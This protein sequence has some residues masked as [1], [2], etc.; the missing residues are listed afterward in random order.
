M[1]QTQRSPKSP[2]IRPGS[3]QVYNQSSSS[4]S[5][6]KSSSGS[7]YTLHKNNQQPK[8]KKDVSFFGFIA[9]VLTCRGDIAAADDDDDDHFAPP[10]AIQSSTPTSLGS[11]QM[12]SHSASSASSKADDGL[13][14]IDELSFQDICK[15]TGNFSAAN[16]IG[17]GGFGTVYKGKLK[18][19]SVIAIKRAK[20]MIYDKGIPKEFKNEILTLSKI[21]HLNLVKFYG[22]VEHGDERIILVEYVSNGTLREHLDGK[23]GNGL[24][25]GER[26]DI[27]I[28]VA[29]AIT[30]L[31]TYTDQPI[32]HR[33]IKSANV[34]ITDKLR[35]KV[36]DFGFARIKVEDP[37]ATH[38][39]TQV[40]GTA[41]YM[42][43][44]YISTY[45]LTDRS[46]V[47]SF[48]VLLMELVTGRLPI[49]LSKPN[50]E[51]YTIKWALQK[52]K[53]GEV[54]LAMDPKLRRNPPSLMV[55]EKV[56]RLAR[57]CVAPTKQS[58]PSMRKCAEILWRVRKDYHEYNDVMVG[59][60]H[61]VQIPEID[62]RKN[63]REFFG[64]E[65]SNDQRFLQSA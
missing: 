59:A 10:A 60:N 39:S 64:I 13:R 6:S 40:R 14:G 21:E 47:Y 17:E 3:G 56:L 50:S 5:N 16:I 22:F 8:P 34:L 54:V 2:M 65:D 9:R 38:I 32:I 7:I 58:R 43:P 30:Y 51:K 29:H 15:A 36:A 45:Q 12:L 48:G 63:R 62:A 31:H 44:E 35:A 41:G 27:M 28:D 52:L 18:N 49:E 26:L 20:K 33:D 25:I 1:N 23:R 46:D 42:D 61:S 11:N 57:Q 37:E 4:T 24:E 19:G 53:A 55:V